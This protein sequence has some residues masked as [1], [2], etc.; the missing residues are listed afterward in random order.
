M[1]HAESDFWKNVSLGGLVLVGVVGAWEYK[2]HMDHHN[3]PHMDPAKNTF[4][5]I[6]IRNKQFPWSCG[7]CNLFESEW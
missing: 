6:H 1:Y 3:D 4:P 7:D 2:V 5:Y